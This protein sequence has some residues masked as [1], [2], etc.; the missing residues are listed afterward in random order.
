M[1]TMDT[2]VT[3]D[4]AGR[5]VIPR[6]IRNELR[7]EPGDALEL[8]SDDRAITLRPMRSTAPLKKE[9]GVWV[10]RSGNKLTVEDVAK[11]I[12]NTREGAHTVK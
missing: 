12:K 1:T 11:V 9:R 6:S 7:I 10:F 8:Q 5:I 4:T 3:I 2:K